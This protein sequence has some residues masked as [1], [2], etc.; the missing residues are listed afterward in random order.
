MKGAQRY[1][2]L[3]ALFLIFISLLTI[4]YLQ[5]T[6][7]QDPYHTVRVCM[8]QQCARQC[9]NCTYE[10]ESGRLTSGPSTCPYWEQRI[11]GDIWHQCGLIR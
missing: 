1:I 4:F 10:R 3:S 9:A 5:E 2:G 6:S 8:N 11:K 7:A